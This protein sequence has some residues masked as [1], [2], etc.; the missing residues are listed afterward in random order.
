MGREGG[1]KKYIESEKWRERGSDKGA[2]ERGE[3]E[4][5]ERGREEEGGRER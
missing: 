2:M 5:R 4:G 3:I 1:K